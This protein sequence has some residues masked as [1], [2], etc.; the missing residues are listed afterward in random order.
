MAV[1]RIMRYVR[2]SLDLRLQLG[3]S[4]IDLMEYYDVDWA[5]DVNDKK[6]IIGYAFM[7]DNGVIS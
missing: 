5:D 2:G 7:F 6:S 4:H 1:K 3:G